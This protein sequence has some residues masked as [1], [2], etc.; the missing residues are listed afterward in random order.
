MSFSLGDM[1][2]S[3][4]L[5][6]IMIT[7]KDFTKKVTV[8]VLGQEASHDLNAIIK[9]ISFLIT[10]HKK[11]GKICDS[12]EFKE[13]NNPESGEYLKLF[14]SFVWLAYIDAKA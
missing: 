9:E 6:D 11:F 4:K 8:A 13:R 1:L 12:L 10:F 5:D 14:M 2:K 7:L 3:H